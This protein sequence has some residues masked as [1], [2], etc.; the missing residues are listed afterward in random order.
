[1]YPVSNDYLAAIGSNARAARLRGTVNGTPFDGDD[2]VLDSFSVQN[3]LCP[4][5]EITL[6]GVYIGM[7]QMTLYTTFAD[8]LSLFGNWRGVQVTAEIGVELLDGTFEYIPI[9]G[10][11]YSIETAEWSDVGLKVTAFDSMNKFEKGYP[12]TQ[13][14]GTAYDIAYLFCRECGAVLGTTAEEFAD[15]PNGAE[16]LSVYPTGQIETYKDAISQLAAALCCFATID[17]SGALVFRPLPSVYSDSSSIPA[18]SRMS[19]TFSDFASYYDTVTVVDAEDEIVYSYSNQN[20]GGLSMNLGTN[21]FLQYG[22]KETKMSI[23]QAIADGLQE[24]RATPFSA[25]I[26]SNPAYDLG[27]LISFPGGIGKGVKGC[28]MGFTMKVSFTTLEGYGE[29]PALADARSKT[30]KEIS[31]LISRASEN[32]VIIHTFENA[33]AFSLGDADPQEVVSIR[34]ATINPKVVNLWHEIELYVEAD[35]PDVPVTCRA[36]LYLNGDPLPYSPVTSW[37]NDGYHL[38]HILY[39]LKELVGNTPYTWEV[40]LEI[41]GGT[42]TINV[43]DIHASLY[44]QGLVATDT[45]DGI[46]DAEELISVSFNGNFSVSGISEN[47]SFVK[48]DVEEIATSDIVTASFVG[49][50]TVGTITDTVSI[51]TIKDVYYIG[52]EDGEYRLISEDGDYNIESEE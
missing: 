12:D 23:R 16:V 22:T 31:G 15:L 9:P 13:V 41:N 34:F 24:F 46:I 27:D 32:E 50:L 21:A 18:A 29:N 39:F 5:T 11:T 37:N 33:S 44:G 14:T 30:D 38:M 36:Y 17:R 47:V 52:S 10:G 6:G 2:V 26:L 1:M 49:G 8:S 45:W 25:T 7:L 4:Q 20:V 51:E 40:V 42:A 48:E 19:T 3:Q 35:D 28:V 43:G